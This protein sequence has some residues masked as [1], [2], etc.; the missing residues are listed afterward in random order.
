MKQL[1]SASCFSDLNFFLTRPGGI[2]GNPYVTTSVYGGNRTGKGSGGG[3]LATEHPAKRQ[4]TPRAFALGPDH[5]ALPSTL[6]SC[7]FLFRNNRTK[8]HTQPGLSPVAPDH[9]EADQTTGGLVNSP[10]RTITCRGEVGVHSASPRCLPILVFST[11]GVD[12]WPHQPLIRAS[13]GGIEQL[14]TVAVEHLG[15]PPRANWSSSFSHFRE[16]GGWEP[17]IS[18]C[19]TP[20]SSFSRKCGGRPDRIFGSQFRRK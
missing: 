9:P 5:P 12:Q 2:W 15:N 19:E 20:H 11:Q 1:A 3:G 18:R 17:K 6:G 8:P 10:T 4:H 16:V 7:G 13:M 14:M